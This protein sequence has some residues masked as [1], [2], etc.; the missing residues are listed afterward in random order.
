MKHD[1]DQLRKFCENVMEQSGLDR[2]EAANNVDSLIQADLRGI[3]SHGVTRL[4]TYAKRVQSGVV[5][6][7]QKPIIL[8]D[9]PAALLIDASNGT[10]SSIGIQVMDICIERA[11]KYGSCFAAVGNANHFGM[12]AYFTMHAANKGMIGVAM[13]NCPASVVPTGGSKPMFGTNPLSIAIPAGKHPSLVLDMATSVVAQGKVILAEKEGKTIPD[14]WAVDADGNPTTDPKKALQGAMLP[15]GGA[16][17]YAIGFIIEILCS[18]LSGAYNSREI[19]NF[20]KDFENPQ[21]LGHFLGVF[22]IEKYIP[23]DVFK[24][25][26]DQLFDEIKSCPPAPGYNEVFIPGE[27]EY[28][29]TAKKLAE[30]I[31]LGDGVVADLRSLGDS[32]GIQWPF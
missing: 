22:D 2:D 32:Y 10:G 6:A 18:T 4:R 8:S 29:S 15:F 16:K 31:D 23:L 28:L 5:K 7:G 25:R 19:N 1:V 30:G 17:G 11:R 13:S 3:A 14:S 26:V 20:W 9:S 27:I 21:N 24:D 12:G